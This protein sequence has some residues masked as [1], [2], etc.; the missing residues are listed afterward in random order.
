MTGDFHIQA[1]R[2]TSPYF[3]RAPYPERDGEAPYAFQHAGT[4]YVLS[5]DHALLGDA[6]GLGKTLE[7]ILVGNAI[8]AEHTLVVCPASLRLNW[9]KEIK[10]WSLA[11]PQKTPRSR[12]STTPSVL[13]YPVLKSKDGISP[14]ANY[15]IVSYALLLNKAILAAILDLRWD[16]LI[17]DEAHAIKDP[18][19][20]RRTAVLCKPDML[21]SVV[22]RI[23]LA[24]GTILPNQP[25]ECYNAI[26]LL[27]WDAID[28]VSLAGFREHYYDVGGGLVYGP[29]FDIPT[30]TWTT[31]LHW[32]ENVRNVPRNLA[33]LQYRLRRHIMVRR[34]KEQVLPQL[35]PKQWHPFPLES[36]P[37]IRKALKH[38]GWKQA[39]KLYEMDPTSFNHGIPVEGAIS[40]ARRELGEAKA[41]A[42]LEYIQETLA[43][44]VYKLVVACWHHSVLDFMRES[45][46]RYGLVY[47]D[48]STSP[49]R[50]QEA[51]DT[52]Q[53]SDSVRIILGQ[54]MP[55]GEGWT[56]TQAQDIVLVE[57]DWVPGKNDQLL[58]RCH[59]IGTCENANVIGHIP[60]VPGTLDEKILSTVI[61]K[62]RS[63]Y[64]ALDA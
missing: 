37:A 26:R 20:N 64:A 19:G 39:E 17:L 50:K 9:E 55:L 56:L 61:R 41:P 23:T 54:M 33:D 60:V 5:R 8:K 45:L 1:S 22:G 6:P 24:S 35:P 32:S 48:G 7:A 3:Y 57:P 16:H 38:E 27:N 30:Q 58:D 4:E 63:I 31:K 40:T 21:P 59:R 51:V 13:T 2:A 25:I 47:M 34:L 14:E 15:V 42:V 62:D 43:S 12:T 52:F 46:S 28:R 10:K 11:E 36:T 18:K 44:G 53:E 29:T 49:K